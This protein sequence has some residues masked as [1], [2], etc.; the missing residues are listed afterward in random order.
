MPPLEELLKRLKLPTIASRYAELARDAERGR[1]THEQYL[2]AL[3]EVEVAH[4]DGMNSPY[5]VW[6]AC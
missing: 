5:P 4:R 1:W 2:M 6:R 3:A